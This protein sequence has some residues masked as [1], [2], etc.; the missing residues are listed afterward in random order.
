MR[1]RQHLSER[2]CGQLQRKQRDELLNVEV[3]FT[4]WEA[5]VL[6]ER[7]PGSTERARALQQRSAYGLVTME[8][9]SNGRVELSQL[10]WKDLDFAKRSGAAD[11]SPRSR[12]CVGDKARSAAR[13]I[14]QGEAKRNPG[15]ARP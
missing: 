1:A 8:W 14:A 15:L 7:W 12:P 10:S 6:A 4:L 11:G 13:I 9:T 2:I 5:K 3:F